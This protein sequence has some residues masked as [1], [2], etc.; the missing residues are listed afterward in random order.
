MI[1][2]RCVPRNMFTVP[3]CLT[4]VLFLLTFCA[5]GNDTITPLDTA[6]EVAK[7]SNDTVFGDMALD[8]IAMTYANI[9]Q[10]DKAMNVAHMT[11]DTAEQNSI[12]Y[13][14]AMTYVGKG[15]YAKAL[16]VAR[17]TKNVN[18]EVL[19]LTTSAVRHFQAG[20]YEKADETLLQCL[21]VADELQDDVRKAEVLTRIAEAY[22]YTDNNEKAAELLDQAINAAGAGLEYGVLVDIGKVY[23]EIGR[24]EIASELLKRAE[25]R[26]LSSEAAKH[27]W[28]MSIKLWSIGTTY[29][30]YGAYEEALAVAQKM[31]DKG[32]KERLFSCIVDDCVHNSNLDRAL[33]IAQMI[34]SGSERTWALLSI[35]S[36]YA[37]Q[38][39]YDE[40][41]Q[42]IS[43]FRAPGVTARALA[44]VAAWRAKDGYDS[45]ASQLFSQGHELAQAVEDPEV[46]ASALTKIASGYISINQTD[47]AS[48][49]LEEAYQTAKTIPDTSS[50]SYKLLMIGY[51]FAEIGQYTKALEV[52]QIT[53]YTFHKISIMVC[54]DS[55]YRASE[56]NVKSR[57]KQILRDIRRQVK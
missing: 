44:T 13:S 24:E 18:Y 46:K 32:T 9:G 41:L 8:I 11:A 39:Q 36:G 1:Q 29:S 53:P 26:I 34:E 37:R 7:A 5:N 49:I 4:I 12:M 35:T 45:I 40:A 2:Q 55:A 48:G 23:V 3:C 28:F 47:I 10:H 20:E 38:R 16:T 15:E 27:P 33:A 31:G 22:S 50:R 57:A 54:T 51:R 43:S 21:Q 25:N 56:S 17:M 52:A 30:R 19:V 6:L 42:L 14:V